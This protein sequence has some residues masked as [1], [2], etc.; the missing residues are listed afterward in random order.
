MA[1]ELPES[2]DAV[3]IGG[4]ISGLSTAYHLC[5][6]GCSNVVLLERQQI[7]CGTTWH[8]AGLVGS[9]RPS[10]VLHILI[11]KIY[12]FIRDVEHESDLATGFRKVGSLWFAEEKE[13]LAEIRRLHDQTKVWGPETYLLSLEEV[14]DFYPLLQTDGIIGVMFAPNE[15]WIS[16]VDFSQ[17]VARA[18]RKRGTRI[19]EKAAVSSIEIENGT[20][21]SV[22]VGE[23]RIKTPLVANCAGLWGRMIGAMAGVDVPL[24]AVEHYYVVTEKDDRIPR[25]LPV[26]RYLDAASYIKEDAGSLLVGSFEHRA[27][28]VD[29][30]TFGA[31]FSFS[32]IEGHAEEQ[33][34]PVLEATMKRLPILGDLGLRTVFCGPESFTPDGSPQ[35]GA[36]DEVRGFYSCCGCNSQGIQCSAA[37]GSVTADWMIDGRAPC[38]VHA[39]DLRRNEPFANTSRHVWD[40][41]AETPG[42]I[43]DRHYPFRQ[44]STSRGIRRSP[45]HELLKARGACFG[46]VSGW[47][48]ANWFSEPGQTPAYD[49]T[50]GPQNWMPYSA[51]EHEAFRKT[52]GIVDLSSF[53]TF[54]VVG[55]DSC[56]TLQHICSADI[57]VEPGRMVYTHWLDE[58]AGIEADLTVFRLDK[59]RFH[60]ITGPATK[61]RDW[62]W[63]CRHISEESD[64]RATDLDSASA[65]IGVFG[66]HARV[67]LEA[68]SGAS[69]SESNFAPGAVKSL[70]IGA[71]PVRAARVAFTGGPG[72]EIHCASEFAAYVFEILEEEGR[73]HEARLCGLHALDSCRIERGFVHYG[74]EVSQ[75]ETPFHV[76]LGFV[77]NFSKPDFLGRQAALDVKE[78]GLG[79]LP[80]RM[81][82]V[83][84]EESAP[85]LFGHEPLLRDKEEPVGF[86]TSAA[87]GHSFGAAIGLG[88]L[89]N[90]DGVSREWCEAGSYHVLVEGKSVTARVSLRPFWK[91]IPEVVE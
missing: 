22:T 47:E 23:Q 24:Q 48:R 43:Y 68:V 59:N 80:K 91:N 54:E 46:Q 13:R 69:L 8:A 66:P 79:K 3:V 52:V 87:Y 16:P 71:A 83:L 28:P 4:G 25:N 58:K 32:E 84:L 70:E 6:R 20:V 49:Y 64:V 7:A 85:L 41:A 53:A 5:K 18:A 37:Y 72:W 75:D 82:S 33:F 90:P 2:A 57:D 89:R 17:A 86:I 67:L 44:L 29:P 78:A 55:R 76:G 81:V 26:L 45:L 88:W 51:V 63:L 50:F 12:D 34:M 77:C 11:D 62:N 1:L 65:M 15:G 27:Q 56:K 31:G 61:R 10:E 14:R 30:A 74:H 21:Q 40:R 9:V 36:A 42:L 60:I 39:L 73:L 35:I 19:F 38:D